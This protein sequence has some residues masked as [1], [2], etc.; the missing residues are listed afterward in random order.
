M[1]KKAL[2]KQIDLSLRKKIKALQ[3]KKHKPKFKI[4]KSMMY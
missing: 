1:R 3:K 4:L 2:Q